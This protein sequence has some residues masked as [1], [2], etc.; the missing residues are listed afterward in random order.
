[1]KTPRTEPYKRSRQRAAFQAMVVAAT[2]VAS[3][4][5]PAAASTNRE[6][7]HAVDAASD[8]DSPTKAAER[9]AADWLA[10][11][12]AGELDRALASMRLPGEKQNEADAIDQAV[13]LSDWLGETRP[14]VEPFASR[15]AG[16]WA[17]SAWRLGDEHLIE[18]ITLYHPAPDG[19]WSEAHPAVG[20]WQVVPQGFESDPA[21]APLVN[22]DYQSLN[23]WYRTMA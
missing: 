21:L 16:H 12:S 19:L 5:M 3:I 9:V 17:V 15:S 20:D 10:M 13:A 6:L 22:A 14:N 2:A 23:E 4:G 7:H 8:T 1:M 18:P 11:L